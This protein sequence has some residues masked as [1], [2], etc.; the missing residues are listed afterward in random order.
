MS[1]DPNAFSDTSDPDILAAFALG[2][3][4]GTS[5]ATFNP[6]GQFSREQA[7]MMIMNTCRA[8]GVNVDNSP[9][10]PFADRGEAF[11]FTQPGIDFVSAHE[12]MIGS[13]GNFT[14]KAD[15][16][17]EQSIVTFNNIKHNEL[18]GR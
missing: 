8:I 6:N 17:R 4:S 16:T 5:A 1:R 11:S 18:P 13:D 9:L 2:I 14:P 7:A 12:I 3:T 15:Y 10:S